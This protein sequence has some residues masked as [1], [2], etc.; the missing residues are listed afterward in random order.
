MHGLGSLV[1]AW[2][3]G[4]GAFAA[5]TAAFLLALTIMVSGPPTWSEMRG[6]SE[7]ASSARD[8]LGGV[9]RRIVRAITA[10]APEPVEAASL[11]AADAA[12]AA[13]PSSSSR[14]REPERPRREAKAERAAKQRAQRAHKRAEKARPQREARMAAPRRAEAAPL[15]QDPVWLTRELER[16]RT[17]PAAPTI[18]PDPAP[19]APLIEDKPPP[20]DEVNGNEAGEGEVYEGDGRL[21]EDEYYEQFERDYGRRR[22]R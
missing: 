3:I 2:A 9:G 20:D 12:I 15:G 7:I 6:L 14:A 18:A 11:P 5:V 13:R 17:A 1:R 16:Q 8:A 22:W 21:S 19:E 10:D 4:L